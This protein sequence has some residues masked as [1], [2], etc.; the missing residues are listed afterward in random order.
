MS[1][2]Q[3]KECFESFIEEMRSVLKQHN[4]SKGNEWRTQPEYVLID[5]LLEEVREFK[6]KNDPDHELVDI[7]NSA[8]LLW[9][10]R[11]FFKGV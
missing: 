6:I 2:I 1:E 5:N 7:A 9:A 11:K 4:P 3:N 10:K 8:Y